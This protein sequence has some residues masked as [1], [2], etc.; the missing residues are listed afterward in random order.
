MNYIL[1]VQEDVS[2][3]LYEAALYYETQQKDLGRKF[4]ADWENTTELLIRNP[5]GFQK[6]QKTY[7]HIALKKFPYLIIYEVH[8]DEIFVSRFINAR[9]EPIKRYK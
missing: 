3:D 1:I 4:I 8:K 9:R 5:L 2:E 6:T 7:R